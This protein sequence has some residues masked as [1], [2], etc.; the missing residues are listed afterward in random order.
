MLQYFTDVLLCR[1]SNKIT[2]KDT[3]IVKS[4]R[5]VNLKLS[6]L[7]FPPMAIASILH[8]L[9]GI[10]LFVFLPFLL[11]V[12]QMSLAS[13]ITFVEL[14]TL[15]QNNVYKL[16]LWICGAALIYHVIA[17]IRHLLADMDLGDSLPT[18]RWTA[19]GTMAL[20]LILTFCLGIVIWYR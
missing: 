7:T 11:Y 1:R 2:N 3:F 13:R 8:R 6:T 18:A 15:L 12:L 14:Q 20:S 16:L 10:A 5:P 17:G 19:Y 9:S 4:K